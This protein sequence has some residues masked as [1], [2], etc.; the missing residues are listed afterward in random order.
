PAV[1]RGRRPTARC[2]LRAREPDRV[3]R[4]TWPAV[5]G[6]SAQGHPGAHG[7]PRRH[8]LARLAGVARRI[9]RS[10]YR[11]CAR[12]DG[13]AVLGGGDDEAGGLGVME[14][15]KVTVNA[16]QLEGEW[17]VRDTTR[18]RAIERVVRRLK[19]LGWHDAPDA[20]E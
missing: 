19:R 3:R 12:D 10:A 1:R 14:H 4:G 13:V 5:V 15:W 16:P 8:H 6:V 2:R 18:E 17:W 7:L 11:A 20:R 9:A